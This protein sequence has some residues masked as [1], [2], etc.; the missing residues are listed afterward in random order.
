M[1][2]KLRSLN[3]EGFV[4]DIQGEDSVKEYR[5]DTALWCCNLS[6]ETTA[7]NSY[8]LFCKRLLLAFQLS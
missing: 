5:M 7:C 3:M 4:L 8:A 2:A 1:P 6:L